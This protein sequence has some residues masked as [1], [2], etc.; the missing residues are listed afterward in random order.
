M[1]LKTLGCH[2][3]E[4]PKHRTSAFL[5]DGR[6]AIDAGAIT[7]T[8]TLKEQQKIAAVIVSHAHLDHVR[9][10]AIMAD[11]R[12]QQGGPPLTIAA[13]AGTIATLKKHYFND[14]LWPDFSGIPWSNPT[15]VYQTLKPEKINDVCG[16]SVKPVLVDHPV[17]AAGFVI[18][19]GNGTLAYSGDTGPTEKLWELLRSEPKLDALI[20]EVAFPNEQQ[21][22]AL[23]A[24]HHTPQMLDKSLQK[25][26]RRRD[27]P[28]LLFHIKP[29]FERTVLR[30][31]ARLRRRNLQVLR[32]GDTFSL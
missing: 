27:L 17:E 22:L 5:L 2:G 16:Y 21:A 24:G 19:S 32:L 4:S 26:G 7:G 1:D 31:L 13:T 30:E 29:V 10:L 11:T 23:K 3:G 15:V 8:L 12:A 6:V 9:D 18:S 20:M 14:K 25:L 28:V